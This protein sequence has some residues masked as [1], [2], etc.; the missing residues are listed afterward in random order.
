MMYPYSDR[1]GLAAAF[2]FGACAATILLAR[3][4]RPFAAEEAN[5]ENARFWR[6]PA[7]RVLC[8]R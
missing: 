6:L 8:Y 5:R 1:R 4:A 3:M 2:L 7:W